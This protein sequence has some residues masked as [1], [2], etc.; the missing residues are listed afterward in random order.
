MDEI[1]APVLNDLVK[2][3]QQ[4]EDASQDCLGMG[5]GADLFSQDSQD[6]QLV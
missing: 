6:F 2:D 5:K 1:D 4:D 3:A